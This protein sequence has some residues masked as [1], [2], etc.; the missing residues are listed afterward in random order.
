VEKVGPNKTATIG[1]DQAHPRQWWK[2]KPDPIARKRG[3]GNGSEGGSLVEDA[4][5]RQK[6]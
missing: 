6:R 4:L 3:T 5:L 1:D 2:I